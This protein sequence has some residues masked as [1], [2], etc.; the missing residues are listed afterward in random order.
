MS[1]DLK[2]PGTA[3]PRGT[4]NSILMMLISY[5]IVVFANGS[6]VVRE[7]LRT[8]YQIMDHVCFSPWL[9]FIGAQSA[10]FSSALSGLVGTARVLQAIALDFPRLKWFSV[11]SADGE[12]RRAICVTFCMAQAALMFGKVNAIAPVVGNFML[13]MFVV[14][15]LACATL[16]LTGAPNFRPAFRLYTWQGAIFGSLLCFSVMWALSP[17]AALWTCLIVA[18]LLGYLSIAVTHSH[19]LSDDWG[20]V[21]QGLLFRFTTR[22]LLRL[23]EGKVHAKYWQPHR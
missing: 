12:P 21:N 13:V 20:D 23:D 15:N 22:F 1:G 14:L 16:E 5:L 17:V 7:R 11:V 10:T 19:K 8:D 2:A 3:I 4:F 9:V 18:A 6:A